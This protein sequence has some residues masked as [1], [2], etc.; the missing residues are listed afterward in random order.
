MHEQIEAIFDFMVNVAWI[1][2]VL[3]VILEK[4]CMEMEMYAFSIFP[5]PPSSTYTEKMVFKKIIYIL[6][7]GFLSFLYVLTLHNY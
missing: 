3:E 2:Q 6:G 5:I 1:F 7:V 4:A